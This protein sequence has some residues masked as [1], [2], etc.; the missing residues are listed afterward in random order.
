MKATCVC[1]HR[2]SGENGRYKDYIVGEVYDLP[3][4]EEPGPNFIADV[5]PPAP[6]KKEVK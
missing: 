6:K 2:V 4:G 1:S 3:D 5:A